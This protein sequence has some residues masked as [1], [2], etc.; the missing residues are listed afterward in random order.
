MDVHSPSQRSFNMSRI[1]SKDTKPE[2]V[3]RRWLWSHGYRYRLHRRDL[4][5]TPDIVLPRYHAVLLIH[6]CFWHRHGCSA[7]TMPATHRNFWTAKFKE[8]VSRDKCVVEELQK[9]GWRVMIVWECC[10]RGKN[11]DPTA[12]GEQIRDWLESDIRYGVCE[13]PGR[14]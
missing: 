1:R 2:L 10:L 4:P 8:N 3:V 5:G 11:A 12:A 14:Q 7:T 6:G 9:D 13:R